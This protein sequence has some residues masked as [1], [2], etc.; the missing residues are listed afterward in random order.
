MEMM[1]RGSQDTDIYV[2]EINPTGRQTI[3]FLHGWPL[4]H[5]A[6]EYQYV[7]LPYR[8]YRCIGMDT[9]GFG[10]SGKPFTGYTY[11]ILADDLRAVVDALRLDN[12]VLAGHSMGGATAIRYMARHNGHGVNKL[13]LFGAAAPSVTTRP[14]FPYGLPKENVTDIIQNSLNDRPSMLTDLSKQ[15]FYQHLPQPFLDWFVDLGLEAS[16]WATAQCALTFRDAWLMDDLKQIGVPTLILHGIHDQVCLYQ[17]A[18]VMHQ[19][20]PNAKLVPF[21]N[22]GHGLFYEERDKLNDELTAFIG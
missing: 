3:L 4:N 16:G 10:R 15:F 9:R 20:I 14:D 1:V 12:F 18:E 7:E 21:E 19:T 13:A 6:F 17:L 5:K 2:H 22:S 11:D 8:G